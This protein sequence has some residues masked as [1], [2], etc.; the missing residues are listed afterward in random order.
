M[1]A[2]SHTQ[3]VCAVALGHSVDG[4]VQTCLVIKLHLPQALISAVLGYWC[5]K[6]LIYID[7]H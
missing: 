5:L 6:A 4:R 1:V 2:H 3:G 7:T